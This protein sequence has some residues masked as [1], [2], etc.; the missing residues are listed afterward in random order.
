[1]R[2]IILT[3]LLPLL[4]VTCK[5]Y[6]QQDSVFPAINRLASV[7][8]T[9]GRADAVQGLQQRPATSITNATARV[10]QYNAAA[11]K[12]TEQADSAV[13]SLQQIP[14][15]YVRQ[16]NDKMDKYSSRANKQTEKT[17]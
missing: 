6:A 4:C 7:N 15:R 16:L 1:M 9:A 5:C 3:V 2:K 14:A 12:K 17:L 10:D 13:K 8:I 11:N